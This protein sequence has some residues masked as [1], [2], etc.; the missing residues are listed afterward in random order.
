MY[1]E[2]LTDKG[3]KELFKTFD[4]YVLISKGEGF[5]I[6]PREA[7]ALGKPCIISNNTAHKTI[8]NTGHVY[9]VPSELIEPAIDP[10]VG[11]C[12]NRFN[13]SIK[14]VR[15]ALREVYTNYQEYVEKALG[16]REWVK[17]YLWENLKLRFL[18]LIKP[19]KVVL[20]NHNEITDDYLMTDSKKL[21]AKYSQLHN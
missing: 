16:G 14:D 21:Y 17:D 4:C 7:L 5:S 19:K 8:C 18:N 6:S 13:C 2:T 10:G 1:H 12:G 9:A 20:G 11:A 3:F 15:K